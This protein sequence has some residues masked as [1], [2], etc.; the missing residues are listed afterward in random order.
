[1]NFLNILMLAVGLSMDSLSVS[2]SSGIFMRKF[3]LKESCKIAFILAFFQAGMTVLGWVLGVNFSDYIQSVDHW[4]AFALL[5]YL[6]GKMIYEA[7]NDDGDESCEIAS[8]SNKTIM[9]LGFATSIDALAVGV[10]MALLKSDILYP[11]IVIFATTFV[12]SLTGLFF[13]TRFGRFKWIN[14]E[15]VGGLILIGIGLKI[16]LEHTIFA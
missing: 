5:A 10:G 15:F 12:F 4:I 8:L 3:R 2:I 16:L 1:M 7:F 9:T 14:I 13:G 11:A 6:G